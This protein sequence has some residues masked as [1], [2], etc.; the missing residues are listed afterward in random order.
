M[1]RHASTQ[2]S[3]KVFSPSVTDA[4]SNARVPVMVGGGG[5]G[6]SSRGVCAPSRDVPHSRFISEELR[7]L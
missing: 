4:L 1:V 5:R 3:L 2:D 6:C 7:L